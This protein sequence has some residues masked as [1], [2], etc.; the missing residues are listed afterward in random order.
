MTSFINQG[1]EIENIETIT[2]DTEDSLEEYYL[3]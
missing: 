1:I 2:T 3:V